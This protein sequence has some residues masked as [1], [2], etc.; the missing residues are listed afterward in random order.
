MFQKINFKKNI[1]LSG[2]S[3]WLASKLRTVSC[4]GFAISP[5]KEPNE[6]KKKGL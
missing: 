4:Y 2:A 1:S 3:L 5:R 6:F